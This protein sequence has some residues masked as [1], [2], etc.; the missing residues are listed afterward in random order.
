MLFTISAPWRGKPKLVFSGDFG[1]LTWKTGVMKWTLALFRCFLVEYPAWKGRR[2]WPCPKGSSPLRDASL[3]LMEVLNRRIHQ[4]VAAGVDAYLSDFAYSND[5]ASK[6]LHSFSAWWV[7]TEWH[8]SSLWKE[9]T[10][11]LSNSVKRKTAKGAGV[12]FCLWLNLWW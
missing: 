10:F 3:L 6:Q 12:Y 5:F 9:Q 2:G 7:K 4:C 8:L 11:S 1:L